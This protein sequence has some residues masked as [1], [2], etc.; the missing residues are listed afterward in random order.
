MLN[1]EW[2]EYASKSREISRHIVNGDEVNKDGV[3]LSVVCDKLDIYATD[4]LNKKYANGG[5]RCSVHTYPGGSQEISTEHSDG[6]KGLFKTNG[7]CKSS[8]NP[9]DI[10]IKEYL[11]KNENKNMKKKLIKLTEGDI[12]NVIK[13]CVNRVINEV[14]YTE[15][16]VWDALDRLRECLDDSTIIARIISRLGPDA[17]VRI[18]KDIIAVECP[19]DEE[20]VEDVE[21]VGEI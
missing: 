12:H 8:D 3:R 11:F 10:E 5:S 20:E 9:M 17:S 7:E 6:S 16:G 21:E 1:K 4:A 13:E 2:F 14:A 18:L 15:M 19:D